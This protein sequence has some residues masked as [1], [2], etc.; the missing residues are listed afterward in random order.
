MTAAKP[1]PVGWEPVCAG[2][3]DI[4]GSRRQ[5]AYWRSAVP[6]LG[7]DGEEYRLTVAKNGSPG[8]G[9]VGKLYLL[10][11]PHADVLVAARNAST[12]RRAMVAIMGCA[13]GL[14][15]DRLEAAS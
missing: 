3:P 11:H 5:I 12:A 7:P 9:W 6:W 10:G 13:A 2:G 4:D 15:I 8:A 14:G 1:M